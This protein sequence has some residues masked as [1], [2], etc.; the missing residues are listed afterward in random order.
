MS[1]IVSV[2]LKAW[3]IARL[4]RSQACVAPADRFDPQFDPDRPLVL[5]APD[6][7]GQRIVAMNRTARQGGLTIG[8]L[9]SNAR[10]KV[11]DLQTRDAD[12]AAD[13]A[14]LYRLALWAMRYAPRA[15]SW[16]EASGADGLFI[17]ITGAAHLFGGEA[18]LL[19]DLDRRLRGFGLVPRLAIAGT[20]GAAW[21]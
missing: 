21:A 2:W 20:P 18:Q 8:D 9:L 1:R 6:K 7:G 14:A 10:S 4:L 3:P 13:A 5:V 11:L 19:D 16:D 12:P 15:A 17:D